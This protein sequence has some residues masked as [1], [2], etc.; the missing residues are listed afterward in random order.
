MQEFYDVKSNLLY[1]SDSQP[2]VRVPLG[3]HEKLTGGALNF[4]NKSKQVY[5]GRIIDLGV[6]E[7]VTTLIW[8]YVSTKRLRTPALQHIIIVLNEN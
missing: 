4:K 1:N 5:L 7:G 2:G 6:R 3:V 8:G